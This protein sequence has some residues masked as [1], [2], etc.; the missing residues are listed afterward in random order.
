MRV[1]EIFF[2]S[3]TKLKMMVMML[4][5]QVCNR[6]HQKSS[7]RGF[8][9][10]SLDWVS[11]KT[12]FFHHIPVASIHYREGEPWLIQDPA[13]CRLDYE[14]EFWSRFWIW[15]LVKIYRVVFGQDF[16]A[17]VRL[18]FSNWILKMKFGREFDAGWQLC[19]YSEADL[20]PRFGKELL[21]VYSIFALYQDTENIRSVWWYGRLTSLYP[22]TIW[23][24]APRRF[25]EE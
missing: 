15:G 24:W 11:Q 25:L 16:E 7:R 4:I 19:R 13:T 17:E 23:H 20:W 3:A 10:H 5:A 8:R 6:F 2:V 21:I 14:A 1:K 12:H 18:R 22:T 9:L